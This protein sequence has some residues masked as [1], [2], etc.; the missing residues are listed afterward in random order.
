MG[1]MMGTSMFSI[2]QEFADIDLESKR[3]GKR[4]VKS[5]GKM[6]EQPDKSI[7][8]SSGSRSEAKAVYRMLGN[9]KLDRQ[10]I[11]RCHREATIERMG[12]HDVILAIQ[13]TTSVNY[14]NHTKMEGLGYNCDK[15]L[16]I[17]IH[18]CLAVTTEGL[19]L[20]LLEQSWYTREIRKDESATHDQKKRRPIEEKESYRWLATMENSSNDIPAGIKL[21]HVCDREGD[22]YELFDKAA[23]TSKSFLIRITQ[24]RPT[25]NNDKAIDAVK[26]L[27]PAGSVKVLIPRDSRKNISE[28]KATLDI[29]FQSVRIKKPVARSCDKHLMDSIDMQIIYVKE[30]QVDKTIEPIEWVLATDQTISNV[31]EAFEKVGYYMQRWKIER[32]HYILKSGCNIEKIQ[33]RRATKTVTLILMYS[34]VAIKILAMTYLARINP[35]ASCAAIFDED[36][37]RVLYCTANKTKIPPGEPYTMN[38]AVK[39]VAA[40]GGFRGCPSDEPPGLKVIWLGLI[41]LYTLLSYIEFLP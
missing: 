22:M 15:A 14:E 23:S 37:W 27:K 38:D 16:G 41:K 25:A 18:S 13:D 8:L 26:K 1:E 4:F 20:G 24:N 35:Q 40:L 34:I 9:E 36:E 6:A 32:F 30:Q 11:L 19:A 29:S 33:Q 2:E 31:N 3:L 7:W 21:I 17:N 28:R 12:G 5:M 10:E 39:Y